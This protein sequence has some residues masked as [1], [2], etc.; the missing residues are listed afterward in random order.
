MGVSRFTGNLDGVYRADIHGLDTSVHF[1]FNA[2]LPADVCAPL[3]MIESENF[4]CNFRADG[5]A[6]TGV[7]HRMLPGYFC[8]PVFTLHGNTFVLLRIRKGV[9]ARYYPGII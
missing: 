5:A 9:S 8:F 3:F 6:N 7:I 2:G 1:L 4:R